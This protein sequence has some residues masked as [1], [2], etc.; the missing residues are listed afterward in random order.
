MSSLAWP[1]RGSKMGCYWGWALKDGN[2][3]V[4][5][6]QKE[7]EGMAGANYIDNKS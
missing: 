7:T 2:H 3:W 6:G 4:S 1:Q 5:W